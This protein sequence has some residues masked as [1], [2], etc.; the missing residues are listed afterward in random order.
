MFGEIVVLL[1][2]MSLISSLVCCDDRDPLIMFVYALRSFFIT[3]L[4]CILIKGC[5][6]IIIA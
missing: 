1:V 3:F 6:L 5:Y 4:I 2:L